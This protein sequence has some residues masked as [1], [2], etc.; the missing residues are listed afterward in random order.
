MFSEGID[1]QHRT[2]IGESTESISSKFWEDLPEML[3]R[4]KS[5]TTLKREYRVTWQ[6]A[7]R[8]IEYTPVKREGERMYMETK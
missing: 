3:I 5:V 6:I 1:K 8:G 4:V 2:V 7:L